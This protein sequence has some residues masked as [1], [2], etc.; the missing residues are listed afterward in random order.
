MSS[1][2]DMFAVAATATSAYRIIQS[3][4]I[5]KV[6]IWQNPHTAASGLG[7]PMISFTWS[8]N[9]TT[10]GNPTSTITD[11]SGSSAQ[12]AYVSVSPPKGSISSFWFDDLGGAE[13]F[14]FVSS[15]SAG[16]GP[17]TVDFD[18]DWILDNSTAGPV[19]VSRAVAGAT[20]GQ[21]YVR[22]PS[23][24]ATATLVPL[25]YPTI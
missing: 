24:N 5:R 11:T 22:D 4:R 18:F 12:P 2:L 15:T 25:G 9:S 14:D 17:F 3:M 8:S 10:V 1:F 21:L 23:T 20:V 6:T 7:M 16:P 19:A 13:L